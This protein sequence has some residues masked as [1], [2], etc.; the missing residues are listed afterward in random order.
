MPGGSGKRCLQK[1]DKASTGIRTRSM[2]LVRQQQVISRT[3]ALRRVKQLLSNQSV[4]SDEA[5]RLI[6]L[7][8]LHGDELTEAGISYEMVRAVER[9]HPMLLM[10]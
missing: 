6:A 9:C 2:D 1:L 4:V 5:L 7:F 3:E 8:Y 10:D